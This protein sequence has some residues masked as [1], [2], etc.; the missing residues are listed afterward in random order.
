[1]RTFGAR[2]SIARDRH[3]FDRDTTAARTRR[4]RTLTQPPIDR[5]RRIDITR[6]LHVHPHGLSGLP[7]RGRDARSILERQLKI[8]VEADLRELERHVRIEPLLR[9]CMQK[10][11]VLFRDGKLSSRSR[12]LSPESSPPRQNLARWRPRH[13][14]KLRGVL[15]GDE[16]PAPKR[17]PY[18]V[19]AR[20][21]S[22]LSA[23]ARMPARSGR[24]RIEL[25]RRYFFAA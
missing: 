1:M 3:G 5:Q 4:C 11:A 9:E 2:G 15:T 22:T 24:S 12:T 17:M 6:L 25:T 23:A 7:R 21:T 19:T 20:R 8:E 14:Q 10:P 18:R 16:T 13:R